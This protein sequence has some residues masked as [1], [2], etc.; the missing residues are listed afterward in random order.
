MSYKILDERESF[1]VWLKQM[2]PD[3]HELYQSLKHNRAEPIFIDRV[4]FIYKCMGKGSD[5]KQRAPEVLAVI[6]V[7]NFAYTLDR[8]FMVSLLNETTNEKQTLTG[9]PTKIFGFNIFANVPTS[10][11]L[12]FN[13]LLWDDG[14]TQFDTSIMIYVKTPNKADFYSYRNVYMETPPRMAAL[15]PD[16]DWVPDRN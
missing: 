3:E 10:F 13:Q 8:G 5:Q 1:A 11:T 12:K 14:R 6:R 7:I 9:I 16:G 15:Y 2:P 4:F